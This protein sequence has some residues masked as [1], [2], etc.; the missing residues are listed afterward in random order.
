MLWEKLELYHFPSDVQEL[1]ISVGSTFYNDRVI[2]VADPVRLSSINR[3]AF[4]DQQEWFLYEHVET[5]QRFVKEFLINDEIDDEVQTS[6]QEERKRSFLVISCHAG[7]VENQTKAKRNIDI[8]VFSPSI[9]IFLLEW[10]LFD[11]IDYHLWLLHFFD[12]T[13]VRQVN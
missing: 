10:I 5:E 13:N 2:L 9:C 11:G 12:S 8:I 4:I 1:S 3:E 6:F 7:S